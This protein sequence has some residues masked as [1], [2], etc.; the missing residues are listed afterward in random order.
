MCYKILIHLGA[1]FTIAGHD[2]DLRGF[3]NLVGDEQSGHIKEVGSELYQEMLDEAIEELKKNKDDTKLVEFIPSINLSIPVLIPSK[4]IE[5][6]SL[7]LA[8]YRRAGSLK[9]NTEIEA[10]KDEMVDRFG[11][12]PN[13]FDNL[14]N[15][16]KIKNTCIELKIESLDSGPNG[17]VMKFNENFDVS[18]MV[19][20]LHSQTSKT[21]KN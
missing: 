1:G 4:Y 10:F 14:L 21:C 9:T 11:A 13:E 5:D 3:G 2:M 20:E 16:V 18:A 6:S 7:R 12:L 19:L 17:F 15:M 8:I